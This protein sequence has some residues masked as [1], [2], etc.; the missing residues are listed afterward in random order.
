LRPPEIL[1]E[2]PV[3]NG[4]GL[5]QRSLRALVLATIAVVV[6]ALPAHAQL[7]AEP[8][9]IVFPFAAGGSGDALARLLAEHLRIALNVPV[10]V[11]NRSGAQGR[12]GLQAVKAAAADGKTLLLTPVAPMSVYQHVYKSLSY[13]PIADFQPISQVASFD[14]AL[15]VGPQVPVKSLK[16][17]V[18]WVKANPAQGNY[19]I[20]AAG[21]LPHFF[22]VLFAQTTGLDLRHVGYRGSAA[23]LVDLIAGQL[24]LLVTTTADL[25]EQHK[26]ARIRILATSDQQRSPFLP[27][28]PTFKEA[29]Y[30]IA[31][32]GW[33]G[34]FAPAGTA[35][36]TVEKLS[37]TL[38]AGVRSP[39]LQERLLGLGLQ[40]TG[41]TAAELGRIQKQDSELWAPAVKASGF[42]P[43][44]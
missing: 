29:G 31:G 5:M 21:S 19:G 18:D 37:T 10:I 26:A 25:L 32:T 42:T 22:G 9:R 39:Q 6:F 17:L 36:E 13:D 2:L 11:E 1:Q 7:A 28:I 14:F 24:P 40:P 34:V 8:I 38:A 20:P 3:G 15:A 33:Y 41:T 43:E 30:D 27:A 12:L 16:Q 44:Q 23:A 35:P 4:G